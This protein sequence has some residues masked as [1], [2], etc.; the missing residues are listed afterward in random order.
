MFRTISTAILP[1]LL[2]IGVAALAQEAVPARIRGTIVSIDKQ[3]LTITAKT[4]ETEIVTLK[5]DAMVRQGRR[6]P[7]LSGHQAQRLRR[8]DR[9]AGGGRC[10]DRGRGPYFSRGHAQPAARP[11]HLGFG[12]RQHP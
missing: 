4:G 2:V 3:A 5:P 10:H 6:R 12:R 9:D 11:H 7:S 8:R 1:G